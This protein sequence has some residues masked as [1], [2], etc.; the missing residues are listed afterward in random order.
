MGFW[1]QRTDP[2]RKFNFEVSITGQGGVIK[3]YFAKTV[4]K[5]SFTVNAAEHNYLNHTFYYPGRVTWNDVSITFVDPGKEGV[6]DSESTSAGLVSMLLAMGYNPP[7]NAA[8]ATT[9]SK[10]KAVTALGD[11]NIRQK[12]DEG[13]TLDEWV[14]LNAWITEVNFGD[15]DYTDDGL[16]EISCTIKYDF[17]KFSETAAGGTHSE[18]FKP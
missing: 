17:A 8:D 3:N 15:L 7:K 12:D 14:L 11:V 13:A 18:T 5:P 1:T 6:G 9:V 16:V 4:T 10:S 2:K